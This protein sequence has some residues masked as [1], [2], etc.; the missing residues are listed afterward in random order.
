MK[1]QNNPKPKPKPQSTM[2]SQAG[3]FTKKIGGKKK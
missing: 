1:K 3:M 2:S